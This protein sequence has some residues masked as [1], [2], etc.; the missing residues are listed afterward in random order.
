MSNLAVTFF[1]RN[2]LKLQIREVRDGGRIS[3][4]S[5]FF[6]SL[7]SVADCR[8]TSRSWLSDVEADGGRTSGEAAFE[9]RR[10]QGLGRL[11][12][13]HRVAAVVRKSRYIQLRHFGL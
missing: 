10:V 5:G 7:F 2:R 13:E 4:H 8:Q 1:G 11:V 6:R 3:G 12:A 9:G